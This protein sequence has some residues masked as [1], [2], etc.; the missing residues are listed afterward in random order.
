MQIHN[1]V[2]QKI[3]EIENGAIVH[4]RKHLLKKVDDVFKE[5]T[6]SV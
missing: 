1:N 3:L 5:D 4:K 6:N 2:K